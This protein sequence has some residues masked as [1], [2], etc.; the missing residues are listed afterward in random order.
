MSVLSRSVLTNREM[1]CRVQRDRNQWEIN[2]AIGA[3][4][5]MSG[6]CSDH[7][8]DLAMLVS[9]RY[10]VIEPLL[11]RQRRCA[12][13]QDRQTI[14]L[15]LVQNPQGLDF[16]TTARF[17]CTNVSEDAVY[18]TASIPRTIR[19]YN[20]PQR[21]RHSDDTNQSILTS[22]QSTCVPKPLHFF[23]ISNVCSAYI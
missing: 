14:L 22:A 9:T 18:T 21:Y 5:A 10:V 15:R 6:F 4:S 1:S 2:V 11:T 16:A 7:S 20:F 12:R 3:K 23:L 13:N 17:T 8:S 19:S